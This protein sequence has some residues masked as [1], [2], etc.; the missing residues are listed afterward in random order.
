MDLP[1]K[2]L[3]LFYCDGDMHTSLRDQGSRT[4]FRVAGQSLAELRVGAVGSVS[5]LSVNNAGSVVGMAQESEREQFDYTAYGDCSSL[6]SG[7]SLLGFNGEYYD[8]FLQGYILGNGYRLLNGMRF[9]SPDSFAPFRVLNAYGYCNGDPVNYVDPS[10]HAPWWLFSPSSYFKMK[11]VFENVKRATKLIN[12]TGLENFKAS[13]HPSDVARAIESKMQYVKRVGA[14]LE[15]IGAKEG[16]VTFFALGRK[17]KLGATA[18]EFSDAAERFKG[19]VKDLQVRHLGDHERYIKLRDHNA[20]ILGEIYGLNSKIK[21]LNA[22][23]QDGNKF[24]YD[25]S[26]RE[27]RKVESERRIH[28]KPI[29]K[30]IYRL[31]RKVSNLQKRLRSKV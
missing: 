2:T 28:N 5:L 29:D 31:E 17:S 6:S 30:E 27:L 12:R 14:D 3:R 4:V 7:R 1:R 10:G 24:D 21:Y 19:R 20:P 11:G 25:L 13:A 16:S 22:Q 8:D 9:S 18:A 23:R 26:D 15:R